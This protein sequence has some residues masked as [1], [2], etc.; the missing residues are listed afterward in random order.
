MPD[1]STRLTLTAHRRIAEFTAEEWDRCSGSD[2]PFVRHTFLWALEESGSVSGKTGWLPQ[3]MALRDGDG[4]LI[5]CAPLYIK[6]HSYGE[7][8][9]DW[10]WAQ[11]YERAGGRYYPKLQ[12]C[13]P[14]TPATGPRLLTGGLSG[15]QKEEAERLLVAGMIEL[16]ER[17]NGSSL[18][19]TFPTAAEA[20]RLTTLGLLPRIG[21]QYHWENPGYQTFDD[22]L[23]TLSSRKRKTLRKEREKANAQGVRFLTLSGDQIEPRHWDAF[24]RFY[25]STVDRKWGSAYLRRPFFDLLGQVMAENVVLVMGEEEAT[26]DLVCGALNLRGGDTLYGRN[27][28]ADGDW[29]FLHFEACYYRAMDYA[30]AHG[31]RWVEAGAQGEHKVQRGYLP[32]TTYSAHYLAD[33]GFKQAVAD[34]LEQETQAVIED[35]E[36]LRACG[37]YRTESD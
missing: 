11:A 31:L 29:K 33:P 36:A 22:F 27:W 28:G 3:H 6:S 26:G 8:V 30:I 35:M 17:I 23:T 10:S 1:G 16:C 5:A 12:V 25:L 15:P 32:R 34:F 9:F 4:R 7:Y 24:Y 19:I 21:Q 18:H 37:P 20:D 13:V 2:N 14:F